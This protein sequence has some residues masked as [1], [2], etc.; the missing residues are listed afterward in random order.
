MTLCFWKTEPFC[1][2]RDVSVTVTKTD[3]TSS[4][5]NR[6]DLP[7]SQASRLV[8]SLLENIK[9]TLASGEDILISG[10][11]KFCVKDKKTRRGRNPQTGDNMILDGRRVVTFRYSSDLKE[12][13]NRKAGSNR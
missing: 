11:G 5:H 3:L 1:L 8:E 4:I 10:F 9:K 12:K 7:K 13:M 2:R 6:L